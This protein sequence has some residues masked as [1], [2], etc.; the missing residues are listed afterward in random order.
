LKRKNPYPPLGCL[1]L[2]IKQR[3]LFKAEDVTKYRVGRGD[4]SEENDFIRKDF[5]AIILSEEITNE[6]DSVVKDIENTLRTHFNDEGIEV[7]TL[8]ILSEQHGKVIKRGVSLEI[9][10]ESMNRDKREVEDV[11]NKVLQSRYTEFDL[12]VVSKI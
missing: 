11:I 3:Q 1:P 5:E 6:Y 9:I 4:M 7:L 2:Q 12:N 10:S 8:E